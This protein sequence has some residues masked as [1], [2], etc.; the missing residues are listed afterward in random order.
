MKYALVQAV[1]E[2]SNLGGW[3]AFQRNASDLIASSSQK[4]AQNPDALLFDL[5]SES[6]TFAK[7]LSLAE[8]FEVAYEVL[9]FDQ[10]PTRFS[11]RLD[12]TE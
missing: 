10:S 11:R 5:S 2:K 1:K 7:W 6:H 4:F 12:G 3:V 9:Y 8:Q